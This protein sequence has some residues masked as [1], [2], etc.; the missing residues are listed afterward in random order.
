MAHRITFRFKER[1]T[2]AIWQWTDIEQQSRHWKRSPVIL[3]EIIIKATGRNQNAVNYPGGEFRKNIIY[4]VYD[5]GILFQKKRNPLEV[6]V[7]FENNVAVDVV[8]PKSKRYQMRYTTGDLLA[9]ILLTDK[10]YAGSNGIAYGKPCL[11]QNKTLIKTLLNEL[12]SE[13]ERNKRPL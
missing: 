13:L 5:Y 4:T 12:R 3:N 8:I 6:V 7:I 10:H 1:Q 11:H 9:A 2:T